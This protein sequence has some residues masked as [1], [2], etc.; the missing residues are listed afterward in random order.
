MHV[1]STI[2]FEAWK[3]KIMFVFE[4]AYEILRDVS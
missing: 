2:T 1:V 4:D 3:T